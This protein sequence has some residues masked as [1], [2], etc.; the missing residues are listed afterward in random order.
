[1]RP[2]SN[3]EAI[4]SLTATVLKQEEIISQMADLARGV[5]EELSQ[6]RSVEEEERLLDELTEE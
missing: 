2:Q 6:H 1:M 3:A 4:R 5:I